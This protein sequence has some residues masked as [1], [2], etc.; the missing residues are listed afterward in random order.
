MRT[1]LVM[2]VVLALG[3]AAAAEAAQTRNVPVVTQ[4]QGATFY[5]TSITLTNG[6]E[7]V[8]TPVVLKFS[9]RSPADNSFQIATLTLDPTL[10]PIFAEDET[11]FLDR[12]SI[13][14]YTVEEH[15]TTGA[16]IAAARQ[17]LRKAS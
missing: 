14:A 1:A 5:R 10:G 7:S 11:R 8:T 9:Y 16:Q 13:V 15:V 3:V 6:S 17:A 2:A 12:N 4:I